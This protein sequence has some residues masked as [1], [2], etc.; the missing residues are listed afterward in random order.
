MV[1]PIL[2]S[3]INILSLVVGRQP[4]LTSLELVDQLKEELKGHSLPDSAK[5]TLKAME[6]KLVEVL[7]RD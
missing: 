7:S 3:R 1:A 6:E 4:E 5:A 2:P